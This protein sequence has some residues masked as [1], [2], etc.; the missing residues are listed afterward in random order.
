ML[1]EFFDFDDGREPQTDAPMERH[2]NAADLGL[3][4][5]GSSRPERLRERRISLRRLRTS[6]PE[7]SARIATR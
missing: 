4:F 5:G 6:Y 7:R 3:R 2:A 1:P